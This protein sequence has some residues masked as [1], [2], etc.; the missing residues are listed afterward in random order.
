MQVILDALLRPLGRDL[1][2]E[3]LEVDAELL[4]LILQGYVY[5]DGHV[6]GGRVRRSNVEGR[7]DLILQ[8]Y[9]PKCQEFVCFD[10]INR[11]SCRR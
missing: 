3:T 2:A 9:L 4:R 5:E 1:G 8:N 11:S 10:S 7:F 6:H